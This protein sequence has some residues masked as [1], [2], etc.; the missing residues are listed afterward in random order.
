MTLRAW[1]EQRPDVS[2]DYVF[3]SLRDGQPLSP[4]AVSESIRRLS[5]TAGLKRL[6]GAHSLRHRVGLTF[7]RER[8]APRVTQ[9]Y[10]GH[11]N[12]TTTLEYYQ[13][14]SE[15][16]LRKAGRLLSRKRSDWREETKQNPA[17]RLLKPRTGS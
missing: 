8:V 17:A 14:V 13:D 10:L 6:L 16:D 15:D 1:L 4:R 5:K 3:L 11:T 9:F 7:A 12:I 2:H